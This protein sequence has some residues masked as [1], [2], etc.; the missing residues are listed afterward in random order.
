M[1]VKFRHKIFFKLFRGLVYFY[2]KVKYHFQTKRYKLPKGPHLILF[3]HPTNMDP[4][5]AGVAVNRP[6]YFI[7]N[8][9]LFNIPYVSKILNYL[10][11]PIPKQKSV[12]DLST[13][14]TS[15]RVVKEG[16]N[17]GVSP[18]GNRTYSGKLNHIDKSITK[19]MKLLKIPVVLY[20][21]QGGFG[22][23]PRFA[24]KLRKGKIFGKIARIISVEEV[25]NLSEEE[26]YNIVIN[27]LDVDDTKLGLKYKGEALAEYLES[28]FYICPVCNEFHTLR[29]EG[30]H[31]YC[32]NCKMSA[33]Y[34]EN[35]TFE[36]KDERFKIKTTRELA[37]F[38][39]EFI[40][41]LDYENLKY[42][43]HEITL[44]KT[45]KGKK[46]EAIFTGTLSLDKNRLMLKGESEELV[47][48]LDD[49]I[50]IAILYHNTIIINLLDEKY[51]LAGSVRFN[52]LKYLHL[53]TRLKSKK[54]GENNAFLGI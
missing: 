46:R 6:T 7:A 54:Q 29:S 10:V 35:L 33:E 4:V 53:F 41:N 51:H 31:I 49:I 23:N 45:S 25:K 2:L 11:A 26:L 48:N 18:E 21:I 30:N 42:V 47:L 15:L 39:D 28:A 20:T 52:A 3:N 38:Q 34:T 44:Y 5:F 13:I 40:R 50:S 12:K 36:S 17:I 16:G 32:K 22:V 19:F 9:D 14:R 1:W 24:I 27:T 43:D 8:E 37:D